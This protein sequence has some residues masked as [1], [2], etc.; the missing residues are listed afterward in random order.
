MQCRQYQ[1][2]QQDAVV[3]QQHDNNHFGLK[4]WIHKIIHSFV[5]IINAYNSGTGYPQRNQCNDDSLLEA[6][7]V[8]IIMHREYFPL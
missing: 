3:G 1:A 6:F 5:Q 2:V 4:F 7:H 8:S